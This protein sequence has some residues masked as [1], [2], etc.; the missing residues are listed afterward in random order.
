MKKKNKERKK[1]PPW[2]K[3]SFFLGNIALAVGFLGVFLKFFQPEGGISNIFLRIILVYLVSCI[4]F[5]TYYM[6]YSW[7]EVVTTGDGSWNYS[8]WMPIAFLFSPLQFVYG[9][10]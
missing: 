9:L 2:L 6:I 4:G 3:V 10:M 8:I 5:N 1:F 7:E